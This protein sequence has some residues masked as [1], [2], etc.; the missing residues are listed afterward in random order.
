MK[1]CLLLLLAGL[2]NT[3]AYAQ[4]GNVSGIITD[5]LGKAV[6]G[7]TVSIRELEKSVV[8]DENGHFQ[9]SKIQHGKY[10]L[11]VSSL[12]TDL[13]LVP[14]EVNGANEVFNIRVKEKESEK[15]N[16]VLV[17]GKTEK[18]LIEEKGFAVNVIQTK[19]ADLQSIQTNELLDRSA[20]VR[21]RQNGGLGSQVQY[22]I[23]GLSGNSV[24]ILVDGIPISNYGESFSLN[25]IPAALIERIEV[26]KGVVPAHLSED[27]LGGA[28]NIVLKESMRNALNTSYSFGSLN[29][30]QWNATGSYIDEKSRF[31]ARGSAF[32]N[33]TD[34]NYEVYGNKVHVT[35]PQTFAREY[36]RAKRFNDGYKSAG[37][38]FDFGFT[39]LKWAD[40]IMLGIIYSDMYKEVQHGAT[41]EVVYGERRYTQNTNLLNFT[42]DKT[43]LL[44]KGLDLS[45]FASYSKLNRDLT[46]TVA[47]T[48]NWLGE[49]VRKPDGSYYYNSSGSQTNGP[50]TLLNNKEDNFNT[51]TNLS[52][53]INS[54]HKLIATYL[55]SNY[56]RDEDDV[57][58]PAFQREL[59]STRYL[60]KNILSFSY[61]LNAFNQK[62]KASLFY[63]Y[64][65]LGVRLK[66]PVRVS[67]SGPT[68]V[69]E[70][71]NIQR[72][73]NDKGYGLAIS[74]DL[75]PGVML[76]GSLEHAIRLPSS[77][78]LLGNETENINPAFTLRPENSFNT[79]L[80]VNIG[81]FD[82]GQHRLSSNINVFTRDVKDMIRQGVPTS[83]LSDDFSFENLDN[84]VSRGFDAEIRYG[85]KNNL[86]VTLNSSVFNG[87]FNSQF[88]ASGNAYS[89]FGN[90][91]RN[92]PFFTQNTNIRYDLNNILQK[93]SRASLYYNLSYVH[94][95]FRQWEA[96]GGTNKPDIPTQLVQ[97]LGFAYTFPNKRYVLSFDAKNILDRQVFDNWALQKAGRAF[98]AKINYIIR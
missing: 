53:Q 95:F 38:K 26:Y 57:L 22:N 98:Y 21:I 1:H 37:G 39:K 72:S 50:A 19:G 56:T 4:V 84:V 73:I 27:A 82:F 94:Q 51:R 18:R 78:E 55:F 31:T 8:A 7:A 77:Q 74:Y 93:K 43:N 13:K 85:F 89:Y 90:R 42:Y 9:F 24:R 70:E 6:P 5:N 96:F 30:H 20:G 79:N 12:I 87:R 46:D 83:T 44:L 48:F 23:N 62:L 76:T 29:T 2:L 14:I 64:Y 15:F 47:N 10:T 91:L 52:Y 69:Y 17:V 33:Y 45:V 3:V 16:E 34:N 66:D 40:Q 25:S 32:Y 61:E 11:S 41:M 36:V 67:G 75:L 63:K 65:Q 68:A 58:R 80:G 59:L 60:D 92:E 35:N 86:Q 97:D 71:L 28:I 81:P 49:K 88:D 54:N